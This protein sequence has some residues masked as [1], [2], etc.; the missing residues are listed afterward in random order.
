MTM[1]GRDEVMK[2]VRRASDIIQWNSNT[3]YEPI[4]KEAATLLVI[5][6]EDDHLVPCIFSKT[7]DLV[8]VDNDEWVLTLTGEV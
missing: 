8:L 4:T 1:L 6:I 2:L 3:G 7:I 5:N